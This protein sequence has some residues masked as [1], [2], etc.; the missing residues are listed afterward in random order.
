MSGIGA[1]EA[2][3]RRTLHRQPWVCAWQARAPGRRAPGRFRCRVADIVI[4]PGWR[5]GDPARRLP[6]GVAD[7]PPSSRSRRTTPN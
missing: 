3:L 7:R 6:A 4:R 1:W 5:R 2:R